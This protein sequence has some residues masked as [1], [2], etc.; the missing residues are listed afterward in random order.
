MPIRTA[1]EVIQAL[2]TA[3]AEFNT[4]I[5]DVNRKVLDVQKQI[6]SRKDYLDAKKTE[7]KN[8]VSA[9]GTDDEIATAL[10]SQL[11]EKKIV[12]THFKSWK[13]LSFEAV[14]S[15]SVRAQLKTIIVDAINSLDNALQKP[16][17][18]LAQSPQ[19]AQSAPAAA[20]TESPKNPGIEALWTT[21]NQ[22]F[23]EATTAATLALT[24]EGNTKENLQLAIGLAKKTTEALTVATQQDPTTKFAN[25]S[26]PLPEM[27]ENLL[28]LNESLLEALSLFDAP[29]EETPPKLT[30]TSNAASPQIDSQLEKDL[31]APTSQ[32]TSVVAEQ[33][34]EATGVAD[35]APPAST[36]P[37]A[38]DTSEA[39][40]AAPSEKTEKD[41]EATE[42][43]N[44]AAATVDTTKPL[45]E[46]IVPSTPKANP[47]VRFFATIVHTI[48]S[49][50][51]F[52]ALNILQLF[53][54]KKATP[55]I[56]KAADISLSTAAINS[57]LPI[58][59][60][61]K[62]QE[63]LAE[64]TEQ[65]AAETAKLAAA[66]NTPAVEPTVDPTAAAAL[67]AK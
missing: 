21:A 38:T 49:F 47:V 25:L 5:T 22:L 66:A 43:A 6:K 11:S 19:Q 10:N 1:P 28:Q 17:T 55:A 35:P 31:S 32:T 51:G 58:D 20:S 42:V 3:I 33:L 61:A 50:F 52:L 46:A 24:A 59:E 2:N 29:Q 8:A 30:P 53:K 54:G 39:A 18:V 56:N 7:F 40:N 37:A 27:L 14:Q 63:K 4:A 57:G 34:Y 60:N 41:P 65:D 13:D 62:E 15:T 26:K 16:A 67:A 64:K 9:L 23:T 44:P 36:V 48:A 45:V 12:V